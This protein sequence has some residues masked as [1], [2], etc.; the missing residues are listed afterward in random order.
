MSKSRKQLAANDQKTHQELLIMER[1]GFLRSALLGGLGYGAYSFLKHKGV[2]HVASFVQDAMLRTGASPLHAIDVINDA[3]RG[4]PSLLSLSRAMAAGAQQKPAVFHVF[5][6]MSHDIRHELNLLDYGPQYNMFGTGSLN[7]KTNPDNIAQTLAMKAPGSLNLLNKWAYDI[8]TTGKVDGPNGTRVPL[9]GSA[10][11][12]P[13]L[14]ASKITNMSIIAGVGMP[15]SQKVH[16]NALTPG[17]G[18]LEY[19]VQQAFA[20]YS[21]VGSVIFGTSA[22]DGTGAV[23]VPG[24]KVKQFISAIDSPG[25]YMPRDKVD[26]KVTLFDDLTGSA[27]VKQI[28]TQMLDAHAALKQKLQAIQQYGAMADMTFGNFGTRNLEGFAG[29]RVFAELFEAG[30]AN[31]GSVGLLSHDHHEA[32]ILRQPDGDTGNMLSETAQALA[33]TYYIAQAAF[34]A[35]RDAIVHLSTCSNRSQNWVDDNQH[36]STLTIIIKGSGSSSPFAA[37]PPQTLLIGDNAKS[38]YAEGPKESPVF[39]SATAK[40]LGVGAAGLVG[41]L[42]AGIV[43][44]V[45]KATGA[46]PAIQLIT[47]TA[48]II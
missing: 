22:F 12:S 9:G 27:A 48:K 2:N 6:R 34:A 45:G 39:T 35:K 25:G 43:E 36:V 23:Q 18:N 20:N 7:A 33:G 42:E 19:L 30:M 41:S 32:D 10:A 1:R 5:Y 3:L 31:L 8:L 40:Q 38:V 46:Q 15:G 44:A 21:P 13:A 11:D 37:V 17:Y 28:R 29:M 47:P 26:N 14:D 4:G 24:K 16:G